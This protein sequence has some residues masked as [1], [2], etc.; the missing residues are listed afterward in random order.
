M[1]NAVILTI[2]TELLLG[3]VI[4]TNGAYLGEILSSAGFD[5]TARLSI[6]DRRGE[7]SSWVRNLLNN[8][9]L[10]LTTGGLGP[11][12]DDLTREGVADALG[13][14]LRFHESLMKD[15]ES[16][17]SARGYHMTPNNR[18]Q[19]YIPE[20]ARPFSNPVGT[21]P[22]FYYRTEAGREV[23]C[24]PGV[25]KEM[26]LLMER[27]IMPHLRE[28]FGMGGLTK[29]TRIIKVCGLGES[30]VDQQ[31]G[32]LMETEG[33]PLVGLLASPGMIRILIT[34]EGEDET[35]VSQEIE[36][37]ERKIRQRLGDLIFGAD[38]Q[39]L[40]GVVVDKLGKLAGVLSVEDSATGGEVLHRILK[41]FDG[42]Y[43]LEGNL[44]FKN[45]LLRPKN[46]NEEGVF[47]TVKL[48]IYS[49]SPDDDGLKVF[50][51]FLQGR[52]KEDKIRVR[53][54]GPKG[55]VR[56]RLGIIAI[57]RLRRWL[58]DAVYETP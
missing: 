16:I 22:A 18:R 43:H 39:T 42:S 51:I 3:K 32:D 47:P 35:K 48:G 54:G 38:D 26:K 46:T 1:P 20:G 56:T 57:D 41:T 33:N 28:V 45:D 50:E 30:G 53:L 31:I 9:D 34:A 5:V 49:L 40:E 8:T 52:G 2:G 44:D 4:D 25:P 36:K 11:T 6:G 37:V 24:L 12:K 10:I 17:F 14:P 15:I 7:I 55:E 27:E 58:D 21:A 23:V 29:R 19:A 13:V